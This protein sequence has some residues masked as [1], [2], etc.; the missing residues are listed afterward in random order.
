MK[1]RLLYNLFFSVIFSIMII[2]SGYTQNNTDSL[3]RISSQDVLVN[4]DAGIKRL[5][6]LY[7]NAQTS[8]DDK[9]YALMLMSTGY[10]TKRDYQTAL[11]TSLKLLDFTPKSSNYKLKINAFNTIGGNY[12]QLNMTEKATEYLDKALNIAR[13]HV[14]TDSTLHGQLGVNYGLKG[15]LLREQLSTTNALS[16]FEKAIKEFNL[17][18]DN[19]RLKLINLCI[20]YFNQGNCYLD[21][22]NLNQAKLSFEK[23]AQFADSIKLAPL[24]SSTKKVLA[25]LEVINGNTDASLDLLLSEEKYIE[26]LKDF[27][28]K[29]ATYDAISNNY[30]VLKNW[31]QHEVYFK[32]ARRAE[33]QFKV[34]EL[35]HINASLS[36]I[37]SKE[38]KQIEQLKQKYAYIRYILI[39][40]ILII[41]LVLLR[42]LVKSQNKI[43]A[44]QKQIKFSKT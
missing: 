43:N 10:T 19:E 23:S 44:L 9:I 3:I 27:A 16:Y 6:E 33:R 34:S 25:K 31:E 42:Y 7:K 17:V 26:K 21:L 2:T 15:Q 14:A 24:V 20:M 8:T 36:E 32:K 22:K 11:S 12:Q 41:A 40:L 29:S 18:K 13:R 35:K 38:N 28:V 4:P 1:T 30:L 5:Q 39:A 37:L